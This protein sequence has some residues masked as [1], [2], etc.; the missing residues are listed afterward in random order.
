MSTNPSFVCSGRKIV[1][2]VCTIDDIMVGDGDGGADGVRVGNAVGS[3]VGF[4]VG[5]SER[6]HWNH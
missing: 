6:T 1:V 2:F 4:K 3:D 5:I